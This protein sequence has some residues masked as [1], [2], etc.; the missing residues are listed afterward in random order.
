MTASIKEICTAKGNTEE[1]EDEESE[2]EIHSDDDGAL[3]DAK[4]T[5]RRAADATRKKDGTQIRDWDPQTQPLLLRARKKQ[6]HYIITEEAFPNDKVANTEAIRN[7]R[8]VLLEE[9]DSRGNKI[10]K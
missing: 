8:E 10:G 6:T 1:L 3:I 9:Q 7:L 4:P 2:V 5:Q